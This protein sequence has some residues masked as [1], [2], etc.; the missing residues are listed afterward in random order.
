[1]SSS[2]R[3]S[4]RSQRPAPDLN[5]GSTAIVTIVH[6]VDG[7][8]S[9]LRATNALIAHLDWFRERPVILLVAVHLP[10]PSLPHMGTVV[11]KADLE[12]YYDDEC[13]AMLKRARERLT[14]AGIA[15][16]A[17]KAVGPVAETIVSVAGKA[18][19]DLIYMGTRGMSALANMALGSIATRV[20]HVAHIPVVL[21]H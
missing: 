14:T 21:I 18:H 11:G 4:L 19:A 9:A 16:D 6:P 12:R 20:L 3:A 10:I 5:S 7:S 8:D 13:E 15:F 1:M 17:R 2:V